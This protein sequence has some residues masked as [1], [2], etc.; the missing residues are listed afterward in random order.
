MG[1]RTGK[2]YVAGLRD[3]REIWVG[4][5]RV[6]DVTD[7]PGFAGALDSMAG[8][9]DLQHERS[10]DCLCE[11]PVTGELINASHLI[12][13]SR[14]DLDRRHAAMKHAAE[15]SV[16]L[17]GRSPDY[18]NACFAGHAGRS[19]VWGSNGNEEYADNLV[20]YQDDLARNDWALTHTIV[21]PTVD[22]GLGDLAAVG[23]EA[24]L[25]K[26]ADTEHGILVR[27]AMVLSTLA[28]FS[29]EL[30][31]YPGGPLPKDAGKFAV[32]FSIPMATPGLKI[33]C[34][35]S[36]SSPASMYDMPF[37]SRFD[38]QDAFLIFDDVEIP[39]D[40]VFLDGNTAVWNAAMMSGWTANIM[41]QT[42][43]RAEAKLRFAYELI[44][45]CCRAINASDPRTK[46]LLGELW[47]YAEM[48]RAILMAAEAGAHEWGNGVWFP[49]ERPFYALRPTAP[50]W[51]LRVNEIIKLL[52]SHNLLAT[53][54]E[55]AFDNPELRPLLDKYLQGAN[56]FDA[57]ERVRLFR[58]AWDFVGSALG[59]RNELYEM[60]YLGSASR[61]Y[62]LDDSIGQF[63]MGDSLVD[64]LLSAEPENSRVS[65]MPKFL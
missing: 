29:D 23:G 38:E 51:F 39:R 49:D 9:F 43:I 18:L 60:Y 33:I 8:L 1:A 16:G 59:G 65:R 47:T 63:H 24:A 31:V 53:P 26:V 13:R 22:K 32:S 36:F 62:Q 45:R 52:G 42:T 56:G 54:S 14:A 6:A 10:D 17:L 27:G 2:E 48:T 28:P 37:S 21:R 50:T 15:Y 12:P 25:H 58:A 44:S 57:R 3:D 46:Q 4:G 5:E 40:R 7:Y 20:R 34:R 35:D 19:D 30:A 55:A 64:P 41:Q 61:S 11:H